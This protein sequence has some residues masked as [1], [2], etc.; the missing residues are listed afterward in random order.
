MTHGHFT[1]T[2]QAKMSIDVMN[3]KNWDEIVAKVG[4]AAKRPSRG[5]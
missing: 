1:S 2:G 5:N 4:E 3:V